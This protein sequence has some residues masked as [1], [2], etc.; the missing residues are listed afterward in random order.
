[1][2]HLLL[3]FGMLLLP[4]VDTLRCYECAAGSSGSCIDATKECPWLADHC[5]ALRLIVFHDNAV[6][7]HIKGKSCTSA[8]HCANVSVNFGESRTLLT[9]KCCTTDLCNTLPAPDVSKSRSNGKKCFSCN[10]LHCDTSLDCLG[11]EHYCISATLDVN[12][13]RR[14]MKGCASKQMCSNNQHVSALIGAKVTCCDG[15]YCNSAGH[16]PRAGL[17]ILLTPLLSLAMLS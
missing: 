9:N 2:D 11:N 17:L 10:G 6:I 3:F 15:D 16:A 13:Q 1:M 14:T 8:G 5:G 12:G 4:K 7:A